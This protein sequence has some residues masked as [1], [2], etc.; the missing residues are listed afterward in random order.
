MNKTL[1]HASRSTRDRILDAAE[2]LFAERGFA[3]TSLRMITSEAGANLASVNY[4]FQSKDILIQEVFARRLGPLNERRLEMLDA[5]ER[6]AGSGPLPL[7]GVLRAFIDPPIR[8]SLSDPEVG[9]SAGRLFGRMYQQPGGGMFG[10]IFERQFGRIKQ[11]FLAAMRRALPGIPE[12]EI[13]WRIHFVI[14]AL[15][16]TMA[17]RE[18]LKFLSDGQCD[19]T[20]ADALIGRLV[21]FLEAGM[22][23]PVVQQ[24]GGTACE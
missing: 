1:E 12:T 16:H 7:A 2:R 18:H 13:L 3:D 14:G 6:E 8:M 9:A 4:Y 21:A 22:N 11:R 17:G 19:L 5:C 23:A 15:A 10:Q 20:D 24:R